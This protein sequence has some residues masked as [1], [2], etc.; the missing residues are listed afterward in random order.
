MRTWS[1]SSPKWLLSAPEPLAAALCVVAQSGSASDDCNST[2][3]I[4]AADPELQKQQTLFCVGK[5]QA[6]GDLEQALR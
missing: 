1:S 5:L 6:L 3:G 2:E 4:R